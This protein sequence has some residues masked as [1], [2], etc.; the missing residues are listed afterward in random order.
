MNNP[1]SRASCE[2]TYRGWLGSRGSL[3]VNEAKVSRAK[4]V[5]RKA[6]R[7]AH[8][9]LYQPLEHERDPDEPVGGPHELH[10][11]HLAS[12][13]EDRQLDGVHD[14]GDRP[15]HDPAG[16]DQGH[17]AQRREVGQGVS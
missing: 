11:R 4:Y 3:P 12:A 17:R 10:D 13:G 5:I 7:R 16:H 6:R 9:A 14:E 8:Q 1:V 2:L 15:E